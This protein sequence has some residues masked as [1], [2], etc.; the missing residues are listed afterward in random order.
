[1]LT[2]GTDPELLLTDQEGKLIKA[3]DFLRKNGKFGVDG[4]PYIAE[5]RPK[6]AVYPRDLVENIRALLRTEEKNLQNFR[7]ISGPYA[8]DRP[9]GGHI[10]FGVPVEDKFVDALDHQFAIILALVEP[11]QEAMRRRTIPL[12]GNNN[13]K[14]YGLLAD[15][16]VKPWGFEYRTPSSFIVSPG[17]A[18]GTLTLA[19]AVVS[20]EM[21]GGKSAWSK[22]SP[23]QRKVLKFAA[24]DFHN[25]NK[26][27]FKEKLADL[28]TLIKQMRYFQAGQEGH[29]LWSVVSYL[30]GNVIQK[31]GF[32]ANRDIKTRWFTEKSAEVDPKT[33]PSVITIKESL[34]TNEPLTNQDL[35]GILNT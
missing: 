4:H 13:G 14:P 18:L 29:N 2:I 33:K 1:M 3:L 25:C 21:V 34:M 16:R 24:Q 11:Q 15:I 9:M 35:W 19:K 27:I 12:G 6:H 30:K 22:I 23:A 10:H 26:P 32:V 20:E 5:L 17:V 8:K 28:W 7:W 31:E